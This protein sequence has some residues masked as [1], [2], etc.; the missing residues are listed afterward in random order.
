MA[1][2]SS[3]F[4]F[5]GIDTDKAEIDLVLKHDGLEVHTDDLND[6]RAQALLPKSG[7]LS[8]TATDIPVPALVQALANTIPELTSGDTARAQAGQFALMGAM[9]TTLAQA[10]IKLKVDPSWLDA[11]KAHLTADGAFTLAMGVPTGTLNLGLTGLDD[12]TALF[13]ATQDPVSMNALPVLQQMH[14]LAKR[15]NGADGKP[16]DK[17]QLDY[18][19]GGVITV[20]GQPLGGP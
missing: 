20:N 19:A 7:S 12:V 5:K 2:A 13:N 4:A 10:N 18:A 16:V 1:H 14:A 6:P 17:F 8:F 11:A 15:E 3:D 9:M